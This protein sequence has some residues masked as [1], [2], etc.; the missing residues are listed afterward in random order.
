[1]IERRRDLGRRRGSRAASCRRPRPDWRRG[2]ARRGRSPRS[3]CGR[4]ARRVASRRDGRARARARRDAPRG[5]K[6]RLMRGIVGGQQQVGFG[7][8]LHV[9]EGVGR[10]HPRLQRRRGRGGCRRPR[11]WPRPRR[12]SQASP[13]ARRAPSRE[14]LRRC[15]HRRGH[16]ARAAGRTRAGAAAR[17]GVVLGRLVARGQA[18]RPPASN[19]CASAGKDVAEQAGHPQRHVDARAGPAAPAA[20][21]RTPMTRSR[22]VVP[23]RARAPPDA[24]PSR[25]PR[26]PCA[27]WP[28]PHR[29]TTS[30]RGQSP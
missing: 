20:R 8:V 4:G 30:P 23:A 16:S 26:P 10:P 17:I 12:R 5:G 1:M 7:Q 11:R 9:D 21:S 3:A 27:S 6:A 22:P 19:S 24:A 28:M 14:G 2:R 29:S 13:A 25:I 15:A 18:P